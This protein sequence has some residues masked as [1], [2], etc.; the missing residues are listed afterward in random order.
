[1]TAVEDAPATQSRAIAVITRWW[2]PATGTAVV[3]AWVGVALANS[4]RVPP[5]AAVVAAGTAAL[6]AAPELRVAGLPG[7]TEVVALLV[8]PVAAAEAVRGGTA[9]PLAAFLAGAVLAALY[10]AVRGREPLLAGTV[11]LIGVLAVVDGLVAGG[12][13]SDRVR[14][15]VTSRPAAAAIL[16]GSALVIV[17]V[18]ARTGA[19]RAVLAPVLMASL[20]A[21]PALPPLAVVLGWGALAVGGAWLDRPPVALGALAVVA[22]A[23]TAPGAAI[24]LGAGAVLAAVLDGQVAAACGLPGAV[25]LAVVLVARP[26]TAPVLVAGAAAIA[27]AVAVSFRLRAT[28]SLRGG[29]S[30]ALPLALWLIV[31]PGTWKFIGPGGLG[32]Y[33]AGMA[34]AAAVALLTVVAV[35]AR[36]GGGVGIDAPER[37]DDIDDALT[38]RPAAVAVVVTGATL[39]TMV[40]L[41]VSVIRLH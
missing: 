27:T 36:R 24:L 20:L 10:T 17:A 12:L 28:L 37:E 29:R 23:V 11:R 30:I 40:W 33:D 13:D 6:A 3:L 41:V 5:L 14:L 22:A 1:V 18:E 4:T 9:A 19:D 39:A 38:A 2:W 25:A 16:A 21:A 34:R 35:A 15:A 26:G 31:A 32:A 7:P 8:L